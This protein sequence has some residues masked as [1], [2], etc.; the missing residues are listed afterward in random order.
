M[1]ARK[2]LLIVIDQLQAA[3]AQVLGAGFLR[4]PNLDRLCRGGRISRAHVTNTM[5]YGPARASLLTA[6][7]R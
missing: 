1:H 2:N 5:P 4:T 3:F 6:S 7:T